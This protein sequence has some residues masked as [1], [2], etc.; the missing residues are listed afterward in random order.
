MTDRIPVG[1]SFRASATPVRA[2]PV[3][4]RAATRRINGAELLVLEESED[5]ALAPAPTDALADSVRGLT[6]HVSVTRYT[7]SVVR[8]LKLADSGPGPHPSESRSQAPA[9]SV[10]HPT[11]REGP[12][13]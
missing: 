2:K 12:P 1:E 4:S 10:S 7:T 6:R 11:T 5:S 9:A 13:T 3:S 8:R